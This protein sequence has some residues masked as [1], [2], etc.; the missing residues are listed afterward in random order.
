MEASAGAHLLDSHLQRAKTEP[1]SPTN[2]AH[3]SRVN[4]YSERSV[5][6]VQ[7][8]PLRRGIWEEK[9]THQTQHPL[10]HRRRSLRS[11]EMLA[12][13]LTSSQIFVGSFIGAQLDVSRRFIH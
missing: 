8:E 2:L 9:I 13:M 12:C 5:E 11:Q 4:F 7:T 3:L 1:Q 6:T 10:T